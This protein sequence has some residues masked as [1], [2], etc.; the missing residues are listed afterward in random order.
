MP[1]AVETPLDRCSDRLIKAAFRTPRFDILAEHSHGVI[2]VFVGHPL[3]RSAVG[4]HVRDQRRVTSEVADD[5]VRAV[6]LENRLARKRPHD[7]HH[8]ASCRYAD[9]LAIAASV[10][11]GLISRV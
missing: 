8:L 7:L 1:G 6:L 11:E 5:D 2:G 3:L 4:D 9:L 10:P